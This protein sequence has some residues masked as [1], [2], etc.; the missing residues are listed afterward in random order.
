MC[1]CD[2]GTC[3]KCDTGIEADYQMK[4]KEAKEASVACFEATGCIFP[5]E[6]MLDAKEIWY[7]YNALQLESSIEDECDKD[8]PEDPSQWTY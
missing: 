5:Y 6:N 1:K 4:V 2:S 3:P 7:E 8:C